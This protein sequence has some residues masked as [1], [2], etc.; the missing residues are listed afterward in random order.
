MTIQFH[1]PRGETRVPPEAYA[2]HHPLDGAVSIGLLANNFPDSVTFLDAVETA[3]GERLPRA[4][5]RRYAKP[6]AS[7]PASAALVTQIAA[8]CD[9][10]VTA[11]G[12]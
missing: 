10:L 3:L 11:Y 6:G 5:F 1:D 9:A 8:E 2:C 12:H 4:T 7:A